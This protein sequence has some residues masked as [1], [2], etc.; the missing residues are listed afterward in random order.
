[1]FS[2]SGSGSSSVGK[3]GV[4]S[5]TSK[6]SSSSSSSS[7]KVN[8]SS[9]IRD[10]GN[11]VGAGGTDSAPGEGGA[12][13][14]VRIKKPPTNIYTTSLPVPAGKTFS[15]GGKISTKT[16]LKTS[17][18]DSSSTK[19]QQHVSTL[20]PNE[21]TVVSDVVPK[22]RTKLKTSDKRGVE[23]DRDR[24][25][26]DVPLKSRMRNEPGEIA[27][28]GSGASSQ[29]QRGGKMPGS[30]NTAEPGKNFPSTGMEDPEFTLLHQQMEKER[31]GGFK[32]APSI[33]EHKVSGINVGSK[34]KRRDS[35]KK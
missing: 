7:G 5:S 4:P 24:D 20:M 14:V 23:R 34:T 33:S 31:T 10:S 22:V 12:G 3:S 8:R 30:S 15:S 27:G 13:A 18:S 9:K 32:A 2:G 29:Q 16:L 6:R 35:R 28:L 17:A 1:M 26:D 21:R 19:R 11:L 25:L